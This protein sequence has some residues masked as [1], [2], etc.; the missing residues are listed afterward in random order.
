MAE[1][2]KSSP[3]KAVPAKTASRS[4]PQ[5]RVVPVEATADRPGASG[6]DA[7][8][9]AAL[10]MIAAAKAFLDLAEQAVKDPAIVGQVAVTVGA[11]AKGVV[12]SIGSLLTPTQSERQAADTIEHIDVG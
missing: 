1:R 3:V 6:T 7:L 11:V 2:P 4:R 5:E 9:A 8:Q 12:G 10:Q